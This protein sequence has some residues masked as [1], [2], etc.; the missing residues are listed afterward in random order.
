MERV[1]AIHGEAVDELEVGMFVVCGCGWVGG[2]VCIG[3]GSQVGQKSYQSEN[4][5]GTVEGYWYRY[6]PFP[7]MFTPL[8]PY[9]S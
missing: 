9:M 7:Y 1:L 3:V 5:V 6:T 4:R 2:W 8:I